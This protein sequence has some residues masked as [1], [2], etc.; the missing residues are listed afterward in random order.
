[1][2]LL[3][4]FQELPMVLFTAKYNKV[5]P[6]QLNYTQVTA[7]RSIDKRTGKRIYPPASR[8]PEERPA[9]TAGFNQVQFHTLKIDRK[10]GNI[11]LIS[12]NFTIRHYVGDNGLAGLESGRLESGPSYDAQ[13]LGAGAPRPV[14]PRT[15]G[16][17]D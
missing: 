14:K 3:E 4:Q 13:F 17:R 9:R 7:T 16:E 2:I 6:P 8:D 12:P 5:I 1:M 15:G 11:D 10:A